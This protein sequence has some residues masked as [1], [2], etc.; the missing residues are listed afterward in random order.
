MCSNVDNA[1]QPEYM[2]INVCQAMSIR[3]YAN[4][5]KTLTIGRGQSMSLNDSHGRQRRPMSQRLPTN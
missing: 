1:R 2:P 3:G 5:V 4:Q